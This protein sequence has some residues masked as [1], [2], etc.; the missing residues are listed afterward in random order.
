MTRDSVSVLQILLNV[1]RSAGRIVGHG[2]GDVHPERYFTKNIT[3]AILKIKGVMET[4][5][6]NIFDANKDFYEAAKDSGKNLFCSGCTN[7]LNILFT[8]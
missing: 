7:K 1:L 4:Y 8:S 3:H 6:E 5:E 2:D